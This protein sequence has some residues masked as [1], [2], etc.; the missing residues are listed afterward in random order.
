[1]N[2]LLFDIDGTLVNTCGSGLTA[3][4]LAFE[5]VFQLPPPE[6]IPTAGRTDRGIAEDL[7]AAHGIEASQENWER[8]ISAY[9]RHLVEQ[10]PK[11]DGFLLPGVEPLLEACVLR[12]DLRLGLLT[13]N[14]PQGAQIKLDYFGIWHHF[15]FGGFGHQHACRDHVAMAAMQAIR[16]DLGDDFPANKVWVIGDTPLDIRCARH[17][18]ARVVAVATGF[19]AKSELAAATPDLLLDDLRQ[20]AKLLDQL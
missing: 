5:E 1:M 19:H 16:R 4:K 18:G 10:L 14:T 20:A 17:I 9:Q 11:R 6:T 15:P 12:S 13:G 3:L 8:F 7:F 2:V